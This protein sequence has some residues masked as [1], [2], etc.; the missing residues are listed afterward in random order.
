M[1]F[2]EVQLRR[3]PNPEKLEIMDYIRQLQQCGR[4]RRPPTDAYRRILHRALAGRYQ[5]NDQD[6]P[7]WTRHFWSEDSLIDP[8]TPVRQEFDV[9]VSNCDLSRLA[10]FI[11]TREGQTVRE[12]LKSAWY[13]VTLGMEGSVYL[14]FDGDYSVVCFDHDAVD[15]AREYT[16]PQPLGEGEALL[17]IYRRLKYMSHYNA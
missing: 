8:R 17:E 14:L 5:T 15:I 1:S 9:I 11:R 6:I 2:L 3:L 13:R 16:A 4:Q 10:F 7:P 12:Y